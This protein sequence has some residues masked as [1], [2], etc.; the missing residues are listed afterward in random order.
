M[1]LM[2]L[3]NHSDGIHIFILL[4]SHQQASQPRSSVILESKTIS[5][6]YLSSE[7]GSHYFR[8]DDLLVVT[9][10]SNN[11]ATQHIALVPL[12]D[13]ILLV[14]LQHNGSHLTFA[15][16]HIVEVSTGCSPSKILRIIDGVYFICLNLEARYL[17]VLQL[18][19]D[20]NSLKNTRISSPLL[21]FS[22]LDNPSTVSN[23]Q[24]ISFGSDPNSQ[25]IYFSSGRYLYAL[26][27][28]S[29]SY[30]ESG[31]FQECTFAES[32]A[33]AGDWT[34][35]AYCYN[36][37]VYFSLA[38]EQQ[39]NQ[40]FYFEHG[41][42]FVCPNPNVHLSVFSSASYIQYGLRSNN[43]RE[44]INV[45]GM[46]F[47]SGICFSKHNGG[48]LFIYYD[49]ER[50]VY[51]LDPATAALTPLTSKGCFQ[52]SCESLKIFEDRYVVI[53]EVEANDA[54][55]IVIDMWKN[56]S[57]IIEGEHV[58]ADLLTLISDNQ[59]CVRQVVTT[60]ESGTDA[61]QMTTVENSGSQKSRSTPVLE[62]ALSTVSVA[63]TLLIVILILIIT[64]IV[65][66][67]QR[68]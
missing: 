9:T 38:Y 8:C 68:K 60:V 25:L 2:T 64:V 56:F 11:S 53:R 23:F 31:E 16:Y 7:C 27:P 57:K 46:N 3:Q 28:L 67:H 39:I 55:V 20:T 19:L 58:P 65:L 45:P 51:V 1:Y 32:L 21:K 26:T 22:I 50:G 48:T 40:T 54:N 42:P 18:Y 66:K 14:R 4:N 33:Y 30:I 10:G 17:S 35:I 37:S 6:R 13:G 61:T 63:V 34:L 24:F 36:R 47:D 49:I 62:I 12:V 59:S 52:N 43:S 29:Y 41:R 15:G 44:N 5:Q